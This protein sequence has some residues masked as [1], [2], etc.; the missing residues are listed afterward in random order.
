M[1]VVEAKQLIK[2]LKNQKEIPNLL[3]QLRNLEREE[4]EEEEER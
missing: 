2:V 4:E 1:L 3:S